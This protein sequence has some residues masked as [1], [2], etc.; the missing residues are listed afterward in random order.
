MEVDFVAIDVETAC[1]QRHSICQFGA[2]GFK[3]GREVFADEWLIDPKVAFE[4]FNSSIHGITAAHIRAQPC[5]AKSHPRIASIIGERLVVSH[6]LFDKEA[7][8]AAWS[9]HRLRPLNCNWLDSVTVARRTWPHLENH[10]LKT[11]AAH[12]GWDFRH[13]RAVEDAR[14][15]GLIIVEATK[16]A[17]GSLS[18]LMT[19]L[20]RRSSQGRVARNGTPGGTFSGHCIVMSG[21]FSMPKADLAD[22]IAAAGGAVSTSVSKRTTLLVLGRQDPTTFAGKDKSSKHLKAESLL[23]EGHQLRIIAEAELVEML[24]A[25]APPRSAH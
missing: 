18:T 2:V 15:A 1:S 13:H 17:G 8:A 5:F 11:L 12:F 23:A 22:R 25:A 7:V 24:V 19:P 16:M 14:I 6:S 4:R 20:K 9:L 3:D 10:K 21:D